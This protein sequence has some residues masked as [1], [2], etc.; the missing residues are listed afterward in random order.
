MV[1]IQQQLH[2]TVQQVESAAIQHLSTER[3]RH[4]KRASLWQ[5]TILLRRAHGRIAW[6][7][8][9]PMRTVLPL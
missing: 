8:G 7:V 6:R 5:P 3:Q 4:W 2:P 1:Y 9:Q